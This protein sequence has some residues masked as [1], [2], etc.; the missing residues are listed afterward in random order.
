MKRLQRFLMKRLQRFLG[1]G[2]FDLA[3][4]ILVGTGVSRPEIEE[5]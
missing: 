2:L 1:W 3:E 5:V 4:A